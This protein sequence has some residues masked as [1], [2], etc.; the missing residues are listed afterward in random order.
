MINDEIGELSEKIKSKKMKLLELTSRLIDVDNITIEN[1]IN[2][3]IK[4]E[5]EKLSQ[6]IKIKSMNIVNNENHNYLKN[7]IGG[8]QEQYYHDKNI[9][10]KRENQHLNIIFKNNS[11]VATVKCKSNDKISDL[12]EIYKSKANIH[13]NKE[14]NIYLFAGRELNPNSKVFQVKLFNGSVINEL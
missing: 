2:N 14:H 11:S 3:A 6:L 9:N 10:I 12:I 8:I 1:E 4:K 7:N 13:Y 5:S